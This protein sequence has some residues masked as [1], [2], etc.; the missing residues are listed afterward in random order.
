MSSHVAR[1]KGFYSSSKNPSPAEFVSPFLPRA[2]TSGSF[3][4]PFMFRRPQA[5]FQKR[6]LQ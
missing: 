1:S 2:I 4:L 3:R 5:A 6:S